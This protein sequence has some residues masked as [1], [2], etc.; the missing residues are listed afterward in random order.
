MTYKFT[1]IKDEDKKHSVKFKPLTDED[2]KQ[3]TGLYLM[4][5]NAGQLQGKITVTIAD[6]LETL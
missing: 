3:C 1:I 2:K 6:E 5:P 4:R